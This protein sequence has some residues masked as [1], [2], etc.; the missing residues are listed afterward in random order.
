MTSLNATALKKILSP[1]SLSLHLL[2]GA[3]FASFS[4]HQSS[5]AGLV[6]NSGEGQSR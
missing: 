1:S 6:F 4:H 2:A 5:S 3:S